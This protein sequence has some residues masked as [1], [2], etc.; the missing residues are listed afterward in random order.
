MQTGAFLTATGTTVGT[1]TYMAPEQAMAQEIGP[2]TDLYSVGCMAFEMFTGRVPFHDSEAPMAI[3]LRHVNEQIPP[4]KS[5]DD[6]IDAGTSDWIERLLVKDPKGRTQS[7]NEAW[8]DYEEIIIRLLGPRWRRSARLSGRTE[9]L[10]TPKPLTPAPFE[11]GSEEEQP[12]DDFQSYGWGQ[13]GPVTPPPTD[14]PAGPLEPGPIDVPTGPPTPPP[15]EPVQESGF[16]TFGAP[17][18]DEPAPAAEPPAAQAPVEPPAAEPPAAQAPVEPP[19]AEPSGFVTFGAPADEAAPPVEPPAAREPVEPPPADD[20]KDAPEFKTYVEP[21]PLRPPTDE[22]PVEPPA[23]APPPVEPLA[24]APP[25]LEP[26]TVAPAAAGAREPVAAT[27]DFGTTVMP[28]ALKDVPAEPAAPRERRSLVF[29]LALGGALVAAIV[30]GVLIGGGGDDGGGNDQSSTPV[31]PVAGGAVQAKVP[32]N[33]AALGSVPAIRGLELVDGNAFAPDG[34]DG[35]RTVALGNSEA[36]DSTLLPGDFRE[37]IG[38]ED[39]ETPERTTPVKLGPDELQALRM[40]GLQPRGSD[41]ELTLYASPTSEGVANVACLTPRADAAAFKAECEAIANTMQISAGRPFRVG[42]DEGFAKTLGD[43]FSGLEN[44]VA[45]GRQALGRDN[46]TF[47]AQAAAARD[48]QAAYAK[49]ARQLRG[50]EISPADERL[51]SELV[52]RLEATAAAWKKAAS[53]AVNRDRSGFAAAEAPIRRTTREL[54]QQ[55]ARLP[56]A[57]YEL[58]Q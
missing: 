4:V 25:P 28:E 55:V 48:I 33:Y 18:Q 40:E 34:R 26:P 11:G 56:A 3:L 51:R 22:P 15:L 42:A 5:I 20:E 8:D 46:A 16:V 54:Q 52:G 41:R 50:A 49:A 29:P 36:N 35:G 17:A 6:S 45:K 21:A 58:G 31:K 1:P 39:G 32:A 2:W 27:D 10:D 9:Q 53:E 24:A 37:A 7:A 38:L 57:G 13:P 43:T 19:A 44:Q 12:S 23:T 47:R 30:A 14:A